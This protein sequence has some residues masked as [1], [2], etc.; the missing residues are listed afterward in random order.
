MWRLFFEELNIIGQ[1]QLFFEMMRNLKFRPIMK[2]LGLRMMDDSNEKNIVKN[3]MS[4]Y[5]KVDS[6]SRTKDSNIT[7]RGF[8]STIVSSQLKKVRLMR[9]TRKILKISRHTLRRAMLKR[10]R[11][12]DPTKS[13][14]WTFSGRLPQK[15]QELSESLKSLIEESWTNKTCVSPNQR[16]VIRRRII[17]QNC[18]SPTKH[19]LDST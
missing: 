2:I 4:S 18:D 19:F 6:K 11:L 8:T 7:R 15:E 5:D 17:S 14:L 16:D 1:C 10:E 12:D 9:K 13:E 3:V